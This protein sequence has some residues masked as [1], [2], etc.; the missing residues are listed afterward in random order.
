MYL[1]SDFLSD[2]QNVLCP[3]WLFSD[4]SHSYIK[5]LL[6]PRKSYSIK[7]TGDAIMTKCKKRQATAESDFQG[8]DHIS[9]NE[10]LTIK[11][12]SYNCKS[13]LSTHL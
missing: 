5:E 7:I 11:L 4:D 13:K 8:R 3:L 1:H 2:T 6:L 12:R 10:Y 9:L